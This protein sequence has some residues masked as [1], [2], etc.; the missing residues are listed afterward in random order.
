[1][2]VNNQQKKQQYALVYSRYKIKTINLINFF[3][4]TKIIFNSAVCKRYYFTNIIYI[5]QITPKPIRER[6]KKRRKER[7]K[8]DRYYDYSLHVADQLD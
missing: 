4:K 7:K 5:F 6:N 2:T 3:S 8:K 1:M